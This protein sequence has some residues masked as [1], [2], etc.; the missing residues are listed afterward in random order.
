MSETNNKNEKLPIGKSANIKYTRC[1]CSKCACC[2]LYYQADS[3]RHLKAVKF[4]T[5]MQTKKH[6]FGFK[7]K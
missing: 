6:D 5:F 3:K 4:S 1:D 2:V 7:N